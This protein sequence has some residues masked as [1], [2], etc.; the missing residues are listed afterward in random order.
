MQEPSKRVKR[1]LREQAAKAHER[2]LHRELTKLDGRFAEWRSGTISSEELTY[3]IHKYDTGPARELWK[4]YNSGP[5]EISVAYA[6]VV[7]IL[8]RDEV[9][10]ELLEAISR[11]I[12]WFQ[13]E[14]ERG[15]L[16]A[17]DDWDGE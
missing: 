5:A 11:Q 9:P 13:A 16:R 1:L 3:R 15:E 7:G 12:D 14:Q 10:A 4:R 17:P 2:E 6:I 8:D